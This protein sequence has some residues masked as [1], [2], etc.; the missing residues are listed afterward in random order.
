MAFAFF[1][2][3]ISLA[4]AIAAGEAG[5]RAAAGRRHGVP[6][7]GQRQHQARGRQNSKGSSFRFSSIAALPPFNNANSLG[8]CQ[9]RDAGKANEQ[10][11]L[12]N[13]RYRGQRSC[14]AW[15]I[16]YS[17]EMGIDDPVAAIGDKNVAVL[18]LSDHHLARKRRFPQMPRPMRPP[19]RRQA[20]R[21]H[22]HR[23]RKAA[24]HCRPIWT[25][26]RS[27]SCDPRPRPRSSRAATR[28]R[29]P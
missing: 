29:R 2:S 3:R 22:L 17:S 8:A 23:Q 9:H 26:R 25:R 5:L 7:S 15:R 27:R 4:A 20:E 12:D 6:A 10:S 19:G 1:I 21:N 18:A 16:G 24:E 11:V 13:A 14:Q 28:R